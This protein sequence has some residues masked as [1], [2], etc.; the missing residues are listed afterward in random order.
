MTTAPILC[1]QRCVLEGV[2]DD[3]L[4]VLQ[5]FTD[6]DLFV[7]FIPELYDVFIS[8]QSIL[9]FKRNF[10][11]Y[12]Q[13]D[14]GALWGINVDSVLIGFIAII[15][16][17]FDPVLFYAILP[18]YRSQGYAKEGVAKVVSYIKKLYPDVRLHS[19]VFLGNATSLSILKSCGFREV[20]KAENKIMLELL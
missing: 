14:D 13:N 4:F 7:R 2:T 1:T 11:V 10:E 9:Q 15:D 8:E 6:D 5:Q 19:E 17:S 20:S 12:S 3:D 18:Q 16:L